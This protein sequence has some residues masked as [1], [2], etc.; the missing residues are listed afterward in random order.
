MITQITIDSKVREQIKLE[1]F[2]NQLL[3]LWVFSPRSKEW[4]LVSAIAPGSFNSVPYD[5][6]NPNFI[7][8]CREWLSLGAFWF[9]AGTDPNDQDILS[10]IYI[11]PEWLASFGVVQENLQEKTPLDA[12]MASRIMTENAAAERAAKKKEQELD[13]LASLTKSP[14]DKLVDRLKADW[15]PASDVK[16][17]ARKELASMGYELI[18]EG[19]KIRILEGNKM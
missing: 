13:K 14:L 17:L 4:V 10:P 16:P 6:D 5:I 1:E 8:G 12:F 11:M 18:S 7:R 19:D 2:Y 3:S 9:E 15:I